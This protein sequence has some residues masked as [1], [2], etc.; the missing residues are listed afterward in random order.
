[1]RIVEPSRVETVSVRVPAQREQLT[2]LRA[3]TE[4][5]LLI[6]D[7]AFDDL[8]DVRIAIDQIAADLVDVASPESSIACDFGLVDGW[9]SARVAGIVST[10]GAIDE[11][12]FGWHVVRTLTESPTAELGSFEAAL[13]GYPIVVRFGRTCRVTGGSVG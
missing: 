6:A 3:L 7:L 13:G 12:G 2:M 1:M 8:T 11:H 4:T 5:C 9:V 10:R